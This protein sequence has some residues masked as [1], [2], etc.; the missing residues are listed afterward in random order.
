MLWTGMPHHPTGKWYLARETHEPGFTEALKR[1]TNER[2]GL[3]AAIIMFSL[4]YDVMARARTETP[5]QA[6]GADE[7]EV[8]KVKLVGG[9]SVGNLVE[10]ALVTT[11]TRNKGSGS[12]RC[13][14]SARVV[15][16]LSRTG[17]QVEPGRS[18]CYR[19]TRQQ[20]SKRAG[21]DGM[22]DMEDSPEQMQSPSKTDFNCTPFPILASHRGHLS[23]ALRALTTKTRFERQISVSRSS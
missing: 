6:Q 9:V 18:L 19:D 5:G 12:R 23:Y 20:R 8:G 14:R 10:F 15:F 21:N 22:H 17:V 7:S 2:Q 3:L 11:T 13:R 16:P 4:D 1:S